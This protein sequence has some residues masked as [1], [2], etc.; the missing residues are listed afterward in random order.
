MCSLSA[1]MSHVTLTAI[2]GLRNKPLRNHSQRI[3]NA[4]H[5]EHAPLP[6]W[7]IW[8][9]P[10]AQEAASYTSQSLPKQMNSVHIP[11]EKSLATGYNAFAISL[12]SR[13]KNKNISCSLESFLLLTCDKMKTLHLHF[14][15]ISAAQ[16]SLKFWSGFHFPWGFC[17]F[18]CLPASTQ[19]PGMPKHNF[20]KYLVREMNEISPVSLL[21]PGPLLEDDEDVFGHRSSLCWGVYN[22]P[23]TRGKPFP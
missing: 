21:P 5:R 3:L 20:H 15:C 10:E 6:V 7:W 19:H 2:E 17:I 12:Y 13:F 14:A 4:K 1:G 16:P 11:L 22:T 18:P 9:L 8:T 23:G